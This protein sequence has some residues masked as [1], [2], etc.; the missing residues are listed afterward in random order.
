M[1]QVIPLCSL[2]AGGDDADLAKRSSESAQAMTARNRLR[3]VAKATL[4]V[5]PPASSSPAGA[6]RKSIFGTP[7][8]STNTSSYDL[9]AEKG[10]PRRKT[11]VKK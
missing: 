9:N 4:I 5:K 1:V 10:S 11:I 7:L 3:S 6:S 2:A 8:K